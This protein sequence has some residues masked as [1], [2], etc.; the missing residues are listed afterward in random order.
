MA[1]FIRYSRWCGSASAPWIILPGAAGPQ[2]HGSPWHYNTFVPIV[3]TVAG[4]RPDIVDRKVFTVDIAPTLAAYLGIKAPS[5][6]V[7]TPLKEVLQ[8]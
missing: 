7:G 2:T 1:I 8:D 5:G 4:L 3:F 6:A